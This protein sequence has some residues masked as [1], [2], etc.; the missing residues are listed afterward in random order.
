MRFRSK[1]AVLATAA[2]AGFLVSRPDI[3]EN[4]S[5]NLDDFRNLF[6]EA[7]E[8]GKEAAAEKEQE[9]KNV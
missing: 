4:L 2:L 5:N 8:R 7:L 3:R 1:L 6:D 9:L